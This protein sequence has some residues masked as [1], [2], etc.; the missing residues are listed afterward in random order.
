MPSDQYVEQTYAETAELRAQVRNTARAALETMNRIDLAA[1]GRSLTA[2]QTDDYSDA[3]NKYAGAAG[4]LGL[5]TFVGPNERRDL[6]DR[7]GRPDR[8]EETASRQAA[9]HL[10][11]AGTSARSWTHDVTTNSQI[12]DKF[13]MAGRGI[14]SF[15]DSAT[16]REFLNQ[17]VA[18]ISGQE[19]RDLT[20]I[21]G[22]TA[23][24]TF[25]DFVVAYERTAD[26]IF[27]LATTTEVPIG[28]TFT[29]PR[30]TADASNGGT[31]TAE[32]AGITTGDSTISAVT[33]NF[34]KYAHLALW[35][36]ELAEDTTLNLDQL[37]AESAARQ[38]T[39]DAGAHLTTGTGTS[40]PTGYVTSAQNGGT[41]SGTAGGAA[42]WNFIDPQ[43]VSDLIFTV[44][45]PY[46]QNAA[47]VVSSTAYRQILRWRD[48][49]QRPLLIGAPFAGYPAT[50]YGFPIY[51]SPSLATLGSASKSVVFGDFSKYYIGRKATRVDLSAEYK[52]GNDQVACRVVERLT[53]QLVDTAALSY[54]VSAAT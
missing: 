2:R 17:P 22:T 15:L 28:A 9:Y 4:I 44:A 34:Y 3:K 46:R 52:M 48:S 12:L 6:I 50:L 51:E 53:G 25:A 5:P 49:Q 8:L 41:A 54:L 42:S 30:L 29:I 18:R 47:F 24:Q 35:S 1:E 31:V 16:S 45:V 19:Q 43:A 23:P 13:R 7:L 27:K 20:S 32:A 21:A 10:G 33:L 11:M 14:P 40:Q 37:V 36:N 26:P 39:L 38:L